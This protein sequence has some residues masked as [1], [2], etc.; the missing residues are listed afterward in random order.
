MGHMRMLEEEDTCVSYDML[1]L[2]DNASYRLG[3]SVTSPSSE[4]ESEK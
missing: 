2:S 3:R 4:S 1:L